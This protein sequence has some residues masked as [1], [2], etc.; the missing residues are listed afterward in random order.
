M[1]LRSK[2]FRRTGLAASDL[3]DKVLEQCRTGGDLLRIVMDELASRAGVERWAVYDCDNIFHMREIKRELPHAL[4]VHVI[5]DGRD[6]ALSMK[7]QHA[8]P[9]PLWGKDRDL[10]VWALLWQWTVRRGRRD[11]QSF[12][13]DYFEVR[14]EDLVSKPSE[15]LVALGKF[16]DHDLDHHRIQ[17]T[18]VGRVASPNTVWKDEAGSG[19]F[20]PVNR[21]K[22]KMSAEEV[23][24]LEAL[25][26]DGLR[27]FGYPLVTEPQSRSLGKNL[28]LM[29]A[30]YPAYFDTKLFLQSRT[31]MGRLASGTRLE[32][33]PVGP[34]A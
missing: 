8:E 23:N 16:L 30:L 34:I 6:A 33:E 12:P 22:G 15:T 7:R 2:A 11:A 32:L 17:R 3:R 31:I 4:F 26:G 18:G 13:A 27:E 19:T 28:R 9:P 10:F 5:R 1:W 21:W 25:I 14:Y 29:R 24:I 20:S